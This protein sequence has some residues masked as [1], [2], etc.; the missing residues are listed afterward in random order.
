MT[1][2]P[3]ASSQRERI[4]GVSVVVSTYHRRAQLSECLAGLRGQTHPADEV[5][6]VVHASD[7]RSA[8]LVAELGV[9]WP[10]LRSLRVSRAGTVAA[11]NLGL[12]SAS[13]EIVAY[14]DDDAIADPDWLERIVQTFESDPLIAAVGGRDV[15]MENG[16]VLEFAGGSV[17]RNGGPEVGRLEWYGRMLGNHH[18][19]AGAARDVDL[20]KGVNMSFRRSAVTAHGF[21]ERLRGTG[22]QMHAEL[23]IC[24]P[25]RR[26]GLRIVYDPAI[27]VMHFPAPRLTGERRNNE[28][29]VAVAAS[30]HNEA[31]A[32]LDHFPLIQRI[33]YA[34]WGFAIGG[35][36]A[37]GLAAL[38][39]DLLGRKSQAWP[40]F[41]AAQRGRA[42]A[43]QTRRG[44]RAQSAAVR[45]LHRPKLRLRRRQIFGAL[46]MRPAVAQHTPGEAAMLMRYGTGAETL[47]E[48]G[49][50]EGGSAVELRSVMSSTGRLY[51]VDPYEP[52]RLGVSLARIV[53]RRTVD[54]VRRGTVSWIRLR[55]DQAARDW[56]RQIDFLFIDADHSYER[57]ASDWRLWSPFVPVGGHVA[58]HDSVV[59]EGGWTDKQSGP[60][61]LLRE[62]R[63][64]EPD[65]SLV[66]QADST[67][68]LCRDR[69]SD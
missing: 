49:V 10:A 18:V 43:W 45:I 14:L 60:V 66:D 24:L 27:S 19:G 2:V 17:R 64:G 56:D 15:V 6:V 25:L 9:E 58:L 52:G 48:L 31:L 32:L 12:E 35:T 47:V 41:V 29:A 50:A 21:D 67:S 26:R 33:A 65:W 23:S 55:S 22:A 53:A 34:A 36:E 69:Y 44:S 38:M 8:R 61:R 28:D 63:R 16:R 7:D 11:Y 5:L 57:A 3:V 46:R 20:L 30:A 39:R 4:R 51:L 68:I 37:P 40:R 1:D 54:S 13:G 42:G 62:I 59:F